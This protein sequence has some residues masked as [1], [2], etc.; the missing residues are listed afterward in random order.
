MWVGDARRLAAVALAGLTV[1]VGL[2]VA[3]HL[4]R[5]E[6]NPVDEHVSRYARGAWGWL[7]RANVALIAA[8]TACLAVCLRARLGPSRASFG[9]QACLW[10]A[11][12]AGAGSA[13]FLTDGGLTHDTIN[14]NVHAALVALEAAAI[15]AA[16][17]TMVPAVRGHAGFSVLERI[18]RPAAAGTTVCT[19]LF[20]MMLGSGTDG[21]LQRFCVLIVV[22]WAF[23]TA[24]SVLAASRRSV[25][26]RP[27]RRQ[28]SKICH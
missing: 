23:V 28:D 3:L 27:F 20:V 11:A 7:Y 6:L 13:F 9:V 15:L 8:V 2:I 14:G 16:M 22:S 5:P 12:L 25:E 10:I 1:A 17:W 18:S 19:V 4:M 24:I 21:L 26:R